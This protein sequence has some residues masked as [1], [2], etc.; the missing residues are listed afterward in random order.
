MLKVV[1][2]ADDLPKVGDN[3]TLTLDF[4]QTVDPKNLGELAKDMAAFANSQGGTIIVGAVEENEQLTRYE[5]LSEAFVN[6]VKRA[7]D[8][9]LRDRCSPPPAV[10]ART[11]TVKGG[12]I[13]AVTVQPLDGHPVAVS[14]KRGEK[15]P[16]E[17][18]YW[19]PHRKGTHAVPLTPDELLR[20]MVLSDRRKVATWLSEIPPGQRVLQLQ[21]PSGNPTMPIETEV[22][23]ELDDLD[24]VIKKNA[25]T[26]RVL[27]SDQNVTV[28]AETIK[29]V[30]RATYR[31]Y[32]HAAVALRKNNRGELVAIPLA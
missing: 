18:L 8:H 1:R 26:F 27:S 2:N 32:V 23:L 11:I 5:P 7:Y 25:V 24:T 9:A 13:V 28:P 3:E 31:W 21:L 15:T 16:A 14:L 20:F 17:G 12:V 6:E 30:C 22:R 29:R 10:E 19:F 4:K